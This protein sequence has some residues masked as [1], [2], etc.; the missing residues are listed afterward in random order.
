VLIMGCLYCRLQSENAAL[1]KDKL[2]GF[3]LSKLVSRFNN[4][5]GF[6]GTRGRYSKVKQTELELSSAPMLDSEL[7]SADLEDLAS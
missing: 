2:N 1:A 6:S 7:D 5:R 4:D 3:S